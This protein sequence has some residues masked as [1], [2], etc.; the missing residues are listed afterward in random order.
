MKKKTA[1][2]KTAKKKTVKQKPS[3]TTTAS[4]SYRRLI[5][6]NPW[7]SETWN[8]YIP[9]AGN[10]KILNLLEDFLEQ[11]K[12]TEFTEQFEMPRHILSE[13]EVDVLVKYANN[14]GYLCSQNK[15]QG[16]LDINSLLF[17]D[18]TPDTIANLLNKG[19]IRNC[20]KK[21]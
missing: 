20:M 5:E 21:S 8:F 4:S 1:K 10:E 14:D 6:H 2:K 9:I 11:F 12:D 15:L 7:E 18:E 3:T 13:T 16:R 19:G 17:D